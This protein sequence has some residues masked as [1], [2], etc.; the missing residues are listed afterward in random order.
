MS[1]VYLLPEPRRAQ[2][3]V[4]QVWSISDLITKAGGLVASQI[5][6]IHSWSG[7]NTTSATFG[8][9]KINLLKKIQVSEEVQQISVLMSDSHMTADEIG[10]AGIRLFVI[11]FG[12]K[13][14]VSLNVLRYAKFLD[15]VSSSIKAMLDSQKLPATER[16]ACFHSLRVHF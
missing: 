6:F 1:D 5:L 16:A 4:I 11:L 9:G 7:Y 3:K 15:L 12:G 8:H 14:N 2:K 10:K 13:P